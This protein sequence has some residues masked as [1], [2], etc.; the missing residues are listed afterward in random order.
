MEEQQPIFKEFLCKTC[1]DDTSNRCTN[2]DFHSYFFEG[3]ITTGLIDNGL[4]G[5]VGCPLYQEKKGICETCFYF[6]DD[7]NN[8]VC[9]NTEHDSEEQKGTIK[10]ENLGEDEI[11]IECPLYRSKTLTVKELRNYGLNLN[12]CI[13][14]PSY[15]DSHMSQ[16]NLRRRKVIEYLQNL[17]KVLEEE[18]HKTGEDFYK[19]YSPNLINSV[20]AMISVIEQLQD[21]INGLN[22]IVICNNS[23]LYGE[24]WFY[25][26]T[27]V[28]L[29]HVQFR[30]LIDSDKTELVV[31][32]ANQILYSHTYKELITDSDKSEEV[33]G[34]LE[35]IEEEYKLGIEEWDRIK[36]RVIKSWLS[37]KEVQE[38]FRLRVMGRLSINK[39]FKEYLEE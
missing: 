27:K 28:N 22:V 39:I 23:L 7:L 31:K 19:K 33:R 20:K 25:I 8:L 36:K 35:C 17:N 14:Q 21:S 24:I 4:T 12:T 32:C 37:E 2:K 16:I 10:H 3:K 34:I 30:N 15:M 26:R 11:V 29:I 9:C 5:I 13:A 38:K 1:V 6:E 18:G